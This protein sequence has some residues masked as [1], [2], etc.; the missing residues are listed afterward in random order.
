MSSCKVIWINEIAVCGR[1]DAAAHT[2][3]VLDDSPFSDF[4]VDFE[5]PRPTYIWKGN[6]ARRWNMLVRA[7]ANQV[8]KGGLKLAAIFVG[9]QL[10]AAA[11]TASNIEYSGDVAMHVTNV[12][13]QTLWSVLDPCLLG[14]MVH[15]A[16]SLLAS[17][18]ICNPAEAIVGFVSHELVA[19]LVAFAFQVLS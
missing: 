18:V 9:L 4:T 10:P 16:G 12:I 3:L 13:G 7:T 2:R 5:A 15:N 14:Q 6:E 17:D 11:G 19:H 8:W 1:G